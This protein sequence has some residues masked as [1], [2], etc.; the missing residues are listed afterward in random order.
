MRGLLAS[1][2]YPTAWWR[3]LGTKLHNISI[4]SEAIYLADLHLLA[5]A[6]DH[7]VDRRS[8]L[9]AFQPQRVFQ[10]ATRHQ[11]VTRNRI[12][13]LP[14]RPRSAKS[15]PLKPN[16]PS[17]EKSARL[18]WCRCLFGTSGNVRVCLCECALMWVCAYVRARFNCHF[19]LRYEMHKYM[20][21]CGP[22]FCVNVLDLMI[23]CNAVKLKCN[24]VH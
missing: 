4:G 11:N 17:G 5:S 24:K 22:T 16:Q 18:M 7:C 9:N 6:N 10:G 2:A 3:W 13:V 15:I 21:A 23:T 1:D 14:M 12:C 8:E 19:R 20:H